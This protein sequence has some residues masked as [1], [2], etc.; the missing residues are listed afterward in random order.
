MVG[1]ALFALLGYTH[2]R[3]DLGEKAG[4]VFSFLAF[5]LPIMC[6]YANEVRMYAWTMLFVSLMFIYAYRVAKKKCRKGLGAIRGV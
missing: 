3:K 6:I 4:I 1:I 5:F 2:V